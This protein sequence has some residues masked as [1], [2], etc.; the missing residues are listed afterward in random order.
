MSRGQGLDQAF[1]DAA[2]KLNKGELSGV[3]QSSFGYHV[4]KVTDKK[5]AVNPTFD[6][7]KTEV[8]KA[9]VQEEVSAKASTWLEDLKKAAT[10][11][12]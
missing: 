3:V 1:E 2:F 7:K 11:E 6:Q 9:M 10:I 4:I 8:K 5:A 12:K